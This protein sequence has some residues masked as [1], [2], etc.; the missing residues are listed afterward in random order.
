MEY[1]DYYKILGVE[2]SA[3]EKAIKRAFRKLA[4]QYHPDKNPGD[5]RAEERF[6]EIN[7]AYEV[8]GDPAKRAR[9]NQL[10][11]S[12]QAWQRTGGA[13]GGFDWSQWASGAPGGMR[14]E[15][16]DLESI[17]GAGFSDFFTSIF[18]GMGGAQPS[19]FGGQAA[20]RGGDV[21][22]GLRISLTEA[23]HGTRRTLAR[24]G[25]QLEV[26]IP[27]G[28]RTGTRVRLSGQGSRG[29]SQSGDLY[30]VVD[31][32]PDA[33]FE[34]QGDDLHV[35]VQTDMYTVLL[36]GEVT[37]PTP[38]G[39]V[40][41]TVPGGSQPGQTFRLKG[42][43]MPQLRTPSA[44]GDLFARLRVTLPTQLTAEEKD[45]LQRLSKLRNPDAH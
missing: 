5:P 41:L 25:K 12:Y 44:R 2:R 26:T 23:Y 13:P 9:Y 40:T 3:D 14:V 35:E 11:S 30:L 21:E 16:G 4:V 34:R 10:G 39:D 6:K 43:G 24:D 28:A 32:E 19:G 38:A 33:R 45:L 42:R 17:L 1:R 22:H 29:R 37:V 31:V 36:G 15:V 20:P 27:P 18:G 7:E 8:L